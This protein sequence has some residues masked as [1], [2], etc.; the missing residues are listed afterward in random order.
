MCSAT[1]AFTVIL[2]VLLVSGASSLAANI[3]SYGNGDQAY[4]AVDGEIVRGD[5]TKLRSIYGRAQRGKSTGLIVDL[6]SPGGDLSEA[7]AIGRWIRQTKGWT[8][9]RSQA[10]CASACVY[11]FAA[12]VSKNPSGSLLIHRPYLM[13]HPAGNIDTALKNA[14][15]ASRAYFAEMNV[16]EG[17]ADVMFSIAPNKGRPLT[18]VE[19]EQYRLM[20]NDMAHEEE[21]VLDKIKR[22]GITRLEYMRRLREYR[23][24][25]ELAFCLTLQGNAKFECARRASAQYGIYAGD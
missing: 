11:I 15:A 8:G 22:L 18:P 17:L 24:S 20:G 10:S 16:P 12:G 25:P 4:I 19:I 5:L 14:L 6:D 1:R 3:Y 23:R 21:R 13:S 9:I 2:L 7:M